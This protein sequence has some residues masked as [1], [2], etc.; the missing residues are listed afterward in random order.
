MIG[1]KI[2][3]ARLKKGLSQKNISK[4]LGLKSPQSISNIERGIAPVPP[5]YLKKLSKL[6]SLSEQILLEGMVE[7]F[8]VKCKSLR[9][10]KKK[11]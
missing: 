8:V 10:N 2:Q 9:K 1:K 7:N 11:T 6:L 4:A 5:R 3:K